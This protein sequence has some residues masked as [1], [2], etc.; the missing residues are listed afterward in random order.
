MSRSG[1][2]WTDDDDCYLKNKGF[3]RLF[4][5]LIHLYPAGKCEE[6]FI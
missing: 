1:R 4:I 6:K 5:I 3:T 2:E